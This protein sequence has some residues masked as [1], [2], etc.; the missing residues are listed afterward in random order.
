MTTWHSI[1]TAPKTR[2]ILIAF[3]F[4]VNEIRVDIGRWQK[5]SELWVRD[6]F[7]PIPKKQ[8]RGWAEI[9]NFQPLSLQGE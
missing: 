9:P 2:R 8:I 6:N 1:D 4:S 3:A 7:T 5:F